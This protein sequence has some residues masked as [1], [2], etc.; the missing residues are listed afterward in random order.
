MTDHLSVG[1]A[2]FDP[3]SFPV[4]PFDVPAR[5]C[6]LVYLTAFSSHDMKAFGS[7]LERA[8]RDAAFT[9][10]MVLQTLYASASP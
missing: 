5:P 10:F 3:C 8:L 1:A 9:E 7:H 4:E 6:N 2:V